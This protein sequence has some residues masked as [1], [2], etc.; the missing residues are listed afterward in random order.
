M[1]DFWPTQTILNTKRMKNVQGSNFMIQY[2]GDSVCIYFRTTEGMHWCHLPTATHPVRVS[3]KTCCWRNLVSNS[4]TYFHTLPQCAGA[5]YRCGTICYHFNIGIKVSWVVCRLL[6]QYWAGICKIMGENLFWWSMWTWQSVSWY[7]IRVESVVAA[8]G[9][10]FFQTDNTEIE[11][12]IHTN[13]S[14]VHW[15]SQIGGNIVNKTKTNS[16]LL[17]GVAVWHDS[18]GP[19]TLWKY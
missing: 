13:S 10:L 12:K 7:K 1:Y 5:V 19:Y 2:R 14:K 9:L 6:E 8:Q 17:N 4:Q 3:G 18:S 16:C 11:E 15:I